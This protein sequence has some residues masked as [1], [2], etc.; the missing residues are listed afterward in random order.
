MQAVIQKMLSLGLNRMRAY[1][2]CCRAMLYNRGV[3]GCDVNRERK[4]GGENQRSTPK[5]RPS[6]AGST[7]LT[8]RHR[9]ALG[10]SKIAFDHSAGSP[11]KGSPASSLRLPYTS[12]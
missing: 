3:P 10:T 2:L 7:N 5:A 11:G 1:D 4:N 8:V 9:G 12:R 6:R